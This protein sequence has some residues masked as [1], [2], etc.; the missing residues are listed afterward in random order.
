MGAGAS[1]HVKVAQSARRLQSFEADEFRLA[2]A[3]VR[4][5]PEAA[6]ALVFRSTTTM[7]GHR[8]ILSRRPRGAP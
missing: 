2:A 1:F 6:G 3:L 8:Q 4:L 7:M 5:A